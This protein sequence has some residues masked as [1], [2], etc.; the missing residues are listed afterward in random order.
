[1]AIKTALTIF[2]GEDVVLPFDID[3]DITSWTCSLYISDT[4]GDATPTL[5]IT[6]A[7]DTAGTGLCHATLT[8]AQTLT[9]VNP[10]YY[11]E[12]A[13]TNSGSVAVLSYGTL[14]VLPRV[15]V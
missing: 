2:R 1:M 5:S 14:T 11:W 6:G 12:L 4:T 3:E 8:A 9:L 15:P 10:V 7:I 13:R